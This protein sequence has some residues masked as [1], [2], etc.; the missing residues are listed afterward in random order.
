[1]RI[2]KNPVVLLSIGLM[3]SMSSSAFACACCVE[4]GYYSLT[5][6][7]PDTFYLGILENMKVAGPAEFYMTEAGF[8]GTKGL[9][10]LEKDEA[11]GKSI[12]LDVVESF[13]NMTW[14]FKVKTAGARTGT[15]RLPM[16]PRLRQFKV[17]IDGV[18]NGLGVSLYKELSVTGTV[19][20]ATGIFRAASRNTKYMLVF[21]GRGN[22]CDDASDFTRWRVE[23]DGPGAEYAFFGKL[24]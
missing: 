16:P 13:V 10:E 2:K 14:T 23:L 18:D 11:S 6:T 12:A 20:S 5:N 4:R 9:G 8:D 22:G 24:R 3:L 7:R 15:L 1:M 19:R 21:Q 17:D